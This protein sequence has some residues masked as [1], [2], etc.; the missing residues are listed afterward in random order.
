MR[1]RTT[2]SFA[3][4]VTLAAATASAGMASGARPGARPDAGT[5]HAAWTGP[6]GSR[7]ATL[8]TGELVV[9]GVT[10]SGA[11]ITN[12]VGAPSGGAATVARVG[13]STYAVPLSVRDVI[14]SV[15]DAELFNA[16]RIAARPGGRTPVTLTYA[17]ADAPS[18]VPGVEVSERSGTSGRGFIT[19]AS[20]R[21]LGRA[22]ATTNARTLFAGVRAIKPADATN[23]PPRW[24]MHTV[25][26]RLIGRDGRP[27][28][29]GLGYLNTTDPAKGV[30]FVPTNWKG[31]AKVS[32]PSGTY[33]LV[34]SG[35][36]PDGRLGYLAAGREFTVTGPT[37]ATIDLRTATQPVTT[38]Y[39]KALDQPFAFTSLARQITAAGSSTGVTFSLLAP[40]ET[41][42]LFAPTAGPLHGQQ[43]LDE[44]VMGKSPASVADP[45]VMVTYGK[46]D[47]RLPAAPITFVAS[48]NTMMTA[49][50]TVHGLGD[51]TR[52]IFTTSISNES[53]GYGFGVPLT[54]P[55][56]TRYVSAAAGMSQSAELFGVED[57]ETGTFTGWQ[58]SLPTAGRPGSVVI[59]PWLAAPLHSR[60]PNRTMTPGVLPCPTCVGAGRVAILSLP[61][62]DAN[63]RH[64]GNPDVVNGALQ[65]SYAVLADARQIDAGDGFLYNAGGAIPAGTKA[66]TARQNATR[67]GSPFL[68]TTRLSTE[69]RTPLT[70][71]IAQPSGTECGLAPRCRAL[72]MLSADYTAAVDV[73]NRLSAGRQTIGITVNQVGRDTPVGIR[74]VKVWMSYDG[75]TWTTAPVS[76]SG[77]DYRASVTV[78][79]GSSGSASASM[80]VAVTDAAGSTLTE[81]I[82][83]A[84]LLPR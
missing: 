25:T 10:P 50:S 47:G 30:G 56:L 70:A 39:S 65:G 48:S 27:A 18:A 21:A 53:G 66:I 67:S 36:T 83:G 58:S 13:G 41:R 5:A 34:G 63:P 71:A 84:F 51:Y 8:P 75:S 38:K 35:F 43:F 62:S 54:G 1:R 49:K 82:T 61:M 11:P 52:S 15:L 2:I 68:T 60:F 4:A 64:F 80:K 29:G 46:R 28:A 19:P 44:S 32:L 12:V 69:M 7:A 45:Y 17:T 40:A 73:A 77:A 20:S 23:P 22:L 76:G 33:Q 59:D 14:G 6:S 16:T 26:L 55:R 31:L 42:V 3:V 72:P 78:P 81:T 9:L 79:R 74:S 37:T 57:Y 24:P